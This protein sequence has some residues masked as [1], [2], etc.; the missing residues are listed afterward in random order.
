MLKTPKLGIDTSSKDGFL[1]SEV[2]FLIETKEL[3]QK[4]QVSVAKSYQNEGKNIALKIFNLEE[5]IA[6]G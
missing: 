2:I 1:T 5:L 4:Q 6:Q 3:V